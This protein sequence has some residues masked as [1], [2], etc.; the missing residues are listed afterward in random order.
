[1]VFENKQQYLEYLKKLEPRNSA[2]EHRQHLLG[3]PIKNS[4]IFI[5]SASIRY[6]VKNLELLLQTFLH[7]HL[8]P[9]GE[10]NCHRIKRRKFP[11]LDNPEV[12]SNSFFCIYMK[13][14]SH[15]VFILSKYRLWS[16]GYLA[17]LGQIF[18][19]KIPQFVKYIDAILSFI[20]D[21]STTE[22]LCQISRSQLRLARY[23]ILILHSFS[24]YSSFNM[25]ELYSTSHVFSI[26]KCMMDV[27]QRQACISWSM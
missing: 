19:R 18:L 27:I 2:G 16:S 21:H 22:L 7:N 6:K 25:K 17:K 26:S 11:Q 15:G 1:M 3:S 12:L 20:V 8:C 23:L 4:P 14:L 5:S 10:G 24:Y 9:E 13:N